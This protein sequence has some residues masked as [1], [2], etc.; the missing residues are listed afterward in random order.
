MIGCLD[1]AK[2]DHVAPY[3]AHFDPFA[4]VERLAPKQDK[5]RGH[6]RYDARGSE[7]QS[8]TEQ[9]QE[10]GGPGGIIESYRHHA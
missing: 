1:E 10:R 4:H 3:T 5:V 9:P 7:G 8:G 2:A 6:R